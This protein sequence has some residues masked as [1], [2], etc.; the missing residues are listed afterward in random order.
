MP[1]FL[2]RN[3]GIH[4]ATAEKSQK[5]RKT[6]KKLNNL[7]AKHVRWFVVAFWELSIR[8]WAMANPERDKRKIIMP[9]QYTYKHILPT[10]YIQGTVANMNK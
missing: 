8:Q 2:T 10:I 5:K 6:K 7:A 3:Y 4:A 1:N 9:I